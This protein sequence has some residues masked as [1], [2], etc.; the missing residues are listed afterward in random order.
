MV[1]GLKWTGILWLLQ[2]FTKL[3]GK[4][5]EHGSVFSREDF[6]AMTDLAHE[7]GVF[8][9]VGIHDNTQSFKFRRD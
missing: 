3:V 4:K 6:S 2:L 8:Q 7:E 1:W 5:G 9:E